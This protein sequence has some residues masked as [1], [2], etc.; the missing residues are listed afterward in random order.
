MIIFSATKQKEHTLQDAELCLLT[1][2]LRGLEDSDL[3]HRGKHKSETALLLCGLG[4]AG[5][6]VTSV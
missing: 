3:K 5:S 6:P 2:T 4:D 1:K